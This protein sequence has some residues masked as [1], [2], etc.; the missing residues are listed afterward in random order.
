MGIAAHLPA[1]I[2]VVLWGYVVVWKWCHEK[3]FERRNVEG[4]ICLWV[5]CVPSTLRKLGTR[6]GLLFLMPLI[7][8]LVLVWILAD[9]NNPYFW[10]FLLGDL[11][12][13]EILVLNA[14]IV[15]LGQVMQISPRGV[16][17]PVPVGGH[18]FGSF[19]GNNRSC[20]KLASMKVAIVRNKAV[21]APSHSIL[22]WQWNEYED[23]LTLTLKCRGFLKPKPKTLSFIFP[24]LSEVELREML[25]M[26]DNM[27]LSEFKDDYS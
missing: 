14:M 4:E 1:L 26:F 25:T 10:M 18:F 8:G 12:F 23:R 24:R 21:M 16:S 20:S 2:G 7:C 19:K 6:I 11:L 17:Y 3:H 22:A 9:I 5:R 27:A 15:L 13:A